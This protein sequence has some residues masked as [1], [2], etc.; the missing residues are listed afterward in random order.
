MEREGGWGAW[1]MVR[2]LVA[3]EL[4]LTLAFYPAVGTGI[5]LR[6]GAEPTSGLV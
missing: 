5:W 3:A 1:N 4:V 6:L 2:G